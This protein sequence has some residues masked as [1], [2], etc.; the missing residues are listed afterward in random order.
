MTN[1]EPIWSL[2]DTETRYAQLCQVLDGAVFA[3]KTEH[4]SEHGVRPLLVFKKEGWGTL[5]LAT[6]GAPV[7]GHAGQPWYEGHEPA[8]REG[9]MWEEAAGR[10]VTWVGPGVTT[11][12]A[13]DCN[14]RR[15]EGMSDE[16]IRDDH[17]RRTA[18]LILMDEVGI[19]IPHNGRAF[20]LKAEEGEH[21][22]R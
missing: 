21:G 1:Y 9:L 16:Q 12:T 17:A 19:A 15:Y 10:A 3:G 2:L 11:T 4:M 18:L 5:G 22:G 7:I 6:Y 14:P 8:A 13:D 20:F